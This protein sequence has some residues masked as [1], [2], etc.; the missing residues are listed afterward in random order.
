MMPNAN[1]SVLLSDGKSDDTASDFLELAEQIAGARIRITAIAIGAANEALLTQLTESSGGHIVPVENVQ[2][3]PTVLTEAVRETRR[4]IVQ[5]PFQPILVS[6]NE[7]ILAGIDTPPQLHGYIATAKKKIAQVFIRSHKDAPVLA[8]WNFGLGKAV[9]VD[10]GC[11][12]RMGERVDP[13]A[14]FREILGTGG[15]LDVAHSRCGMPALTS[16]ISL[17]EGACAGAAQHTNAITS[18]L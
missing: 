9:A 15:P 13:V 10:I 18:R 8:G 7:P 14:Q 5:E 6:P 3:L 12:T 4:Y 11:Q 2:Q 16:S 1:T 17:Q